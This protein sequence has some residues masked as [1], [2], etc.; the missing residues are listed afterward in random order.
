MVPLPSM[1]K[2]APVWG[3]VEFLMKVFPLVVVAYWLASMPPSLFESK[4]TSAC[5]ADI[6]RI[7]YGVALTCGR[8]E[9]VVKGSRDLRRTLISR[10]RFPPGKAFAPK[11]KDCTVKAQALTCTLVREITMWAGC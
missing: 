7:A 9:S 11:S 1:F 3:V 6:A 4:A 8:G 10:Y 2:L 5:A